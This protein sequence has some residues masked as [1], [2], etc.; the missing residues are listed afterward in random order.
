MTPSPT[1]RPDVVG[2][3]D[4]ATHTVTYLVSDPATGVAAL[5]DPG[6]LDIHVERTYPLAELAAAFEHNRAGHTR[7]KIVIDVA[8]AANDAAPEAHDARDEANGGDTL[9]PRPERLP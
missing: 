4:P 6:Q 2:F 7:G 1:L 5:I 3:F 9:A 8:P